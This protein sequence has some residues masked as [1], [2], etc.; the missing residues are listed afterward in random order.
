MRRVFALTLLVAGACQ[1]PAP[2]AREH[3]V[4]FRTGWAF[5]P[6]RSYRTAFDG[7]QTYGAEPAPRPLA[8][9]AWYPAEPDTGTPMVAGDRLE[10]A[11]D[12]RVA[13]L[14]P[15]VE[16]HARG[17]Y[18]EQVFGTEEE[19]LD[20][21]GQST[22]AALLA[23]PVA[24]R[25]DATPA[26]GRFPLVLYRSGAGSSFEDNAELCE[27][28]ARHG[29]VVVA[30]PYLRGDGRDLGIDTRED[31]SAD[32]EF[33]IALAR[34]WDFVAEE[35]VALVGHSAGAQ[36]IL[37]HAARAGSSG[38]ALVLLDTT[39]D[40]YSLAMPLHRELVET[41]LA[42]RAAL[43][44]PLLVAA[45][46]EA[47]FALVDRLSAA[48]RTYLTVPGLNHDEFISQGLERLARLELE[49]RPEDE[50]ERARAA[51][52]RARSAE[53]TQRVVDFLAG[54]T[55]A[56]VPVEAWTGRAC[57]AVAVP[58]GEEAP[59]L[60]DTLAGAPP[61]PR[62]L[63]ALFDAGRVDE[64]L[65]EFERARDL[66][67]RPAFRLGAAAPGSYAFELVRAGR[68]AEARR[69]AEACRAAE[70]DLLGLFRFLADIGRLVGRPEAERSC[71]EVACAL[72][73]DEPEFA[74]RLRALDAQPG[75]AQS[76]R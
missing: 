35:R 32:M 10:L 5:D 7:G 12:A 8:W 41:V 51:E 9:L 49:A 54:R 22:L 36:A 31:S 39:Q 28:L 57:E 63:R 26:A 14:T 64:V 47:L 67:P 25:R 2:G 6:T 38:D 50:A 19:A 45:G 48:P 27:T 29:H 18:V 40:Y 13:A 75:D 20:A 15:A 72:A 24:A 55:L 62:A 3:A 1:A 11:H 61:T 21:L 76:G 58:V 70:V 30:S 42:G 60:P 73:P 33:L 71:L 16:G 17:I 44:Q 74:E 68:V 56:T 65:A 4:G 46:P 43:R 66:V 23:R 69:L 59:A 37:R 34:S 53:L 52:V